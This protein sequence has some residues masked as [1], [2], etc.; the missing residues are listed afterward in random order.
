MIL[1]SDYPAGVTHYN[2]LLKGKAIAS[3]ET[4]NDG[5]V[6]QGG[7][8]DTQPGMIIHFTDGTFVK[9]QYCGSDSLRYFGVTEWEEKD[10]TR[11]DIE[12]KEYVV[13]MLG[14]QSQPHRFSVTKRDNFTY[15]IHLKG[16]GIS[17]Y[18]IG[19]VAYNPAV[20]FDGPWYIVDDVCEEQDYM[21]DG[22]TICKKG[23]PKRWGFSNVKDAV[24]ELGTRQHKSLLEF[25]AAQ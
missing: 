2:H 16:P 4:F 5:P 10:Q 18:R 11:E 24:A 6:K 3:I 12:A 14:N 13:C 20:R 9:I 7:K 1:K 23:E 25:L 21:I 19:E 17:Q 8:Q 15:E 22:E